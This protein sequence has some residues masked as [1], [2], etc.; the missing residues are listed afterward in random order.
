MKKKNSVFIVLIIF[1]AVIAISIG[2]SSKASNDSIEDVKTMEYD[3][4]Y[5]V[6]AD[7]NVFIKLANICEDCCYYV[8]DIIFSGIEKV[9]SSLLGN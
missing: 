5:Y 1:I 8:V 9:F 7:G 2:L 4:A 6:E 3:S